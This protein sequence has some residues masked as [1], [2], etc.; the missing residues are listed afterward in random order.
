MLGVP[1]SANTAQPR[2]FAAK[3]CNPCCSA[4]RAL[5]YELRHCTAACHRQRGSTHHVVRAVTNVPVSQSFATAD[6]AYAAASTFLRSVGFTNQ[7][8]LARVLDIAMNA[9]SLFVNYSDLKHSRNVN[10]R[11]LDVE[12]DIKPVVEFLLGNGVS[13][14]D[15]VKVI[16]G[17]PP[18]LSYSVPTRLAPFWKYLESVGVDN[19]AETVVERP[20][21]LGLDADQNLRKIVDYLQYI[22]TPPEKIVEYLK[23]TI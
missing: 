12:T 10:A 6:P 22:E 19:I 20:S 3:G 16:S 13:K 9:D 23:R 11:P 4:A 21:L 18:V 14:G 1:L 17:H 7:A 5:T 8:E 15:V 2:T